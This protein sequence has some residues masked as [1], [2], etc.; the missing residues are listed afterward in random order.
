ME[1]LRKMAEKELMNNPNVQHL[2]EKID[3]MV[4]ILKRIERKMDKTVK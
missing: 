2:I 1:K 4:E 3:E